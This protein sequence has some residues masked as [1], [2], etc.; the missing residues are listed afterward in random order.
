MEELSLYIPRR[1]YQKIMYWV[2]KSTFE[3]SGLGTITFNESDGEFVLT[4][5][6]LLE[7]EN[8]SA[9]TDISAKELAKLEYDI[10]MYKRNN[11]DVNIGELRFW[12]HSHVKMPVFWSSIDRSTMK[13]LSTN[14]WFLSTVFNQKNEMRTAYTQ[15]N[16]MKLMIDDMET[17]IY[18]EI[19]DS[20]KE[21]WDKIYKEKVNTKPSSTI[22]PYW[23]WKNKKAKEDDDDEDAFY[24]NYE[25]FKKVIAGELGQE[26]FEQILSKE[27]KS[28]NKELA[29]ELNFDLKD[30][31]NDITL[32]PRNDHRTLEDLTDEE[33][34][35]FFHQLN[36][37]DGPSSSNPEIEIRNKTNNKKT[38]GKK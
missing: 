34:D 15:N 26:E 1:L 10:H 33:I 25:N 4:E 38:A 18:D 24:S 35:N 11:P 36:D 29:D 12:W 13:E 30:D 22:A 9:S 20:D 32:Y 16:E 27:I 23:N 2:N 8:G 28:K 14:G 3:V 21:E 7:Q 17:I 5:V 6:F 19:S 37:D 31:I